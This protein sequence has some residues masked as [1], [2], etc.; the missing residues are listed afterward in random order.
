M[1]FRSLARAKGFRR[2]ATTSPSSSPGGRSVSPVASMTAG[3]RAVPSLRRP[4]ST[5]SP[6]T[7]GSSQWST[8]TSGESRCSF[9]R[10]SRP[11]DALFNDIAHLGQVHPVKTGEFSVGIGHEHNRHHRSLMSGLTSS[12]LMGQSRSAPRSRGDQLTTGILRHGESAAIRASRQSLY[13]EAPRPCQEIP[14]GAIRCRSP[15]PTGDS[16]HEGVTQS[17]GARRLRVRVPPRTV[18]PADGRAGQRRLI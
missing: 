15:R 7:Y 13:G 5:P 12:R 9:S 14:D 10:H 11:P 2:H 3:G 16:G 6:P 18:G 8:S 1:V 17:S 4:A